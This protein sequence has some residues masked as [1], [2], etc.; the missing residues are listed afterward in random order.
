MWCAAK[1]KLKAGLSISVG[2]FGWDGI[3]VQEVAKN[4]CSK[5]PSYTAAHSVYL[6][7]AKDYSF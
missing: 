2:F 6:Y 1:V 3:V 4:H 5:W 7:S